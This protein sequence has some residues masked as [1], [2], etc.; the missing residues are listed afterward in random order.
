MTRSIATMRAISAARSRS[1]RP[2]FRA[3]ELPAAVQALERAVE[4]NRQFARAQR[5]LG[6]LYHALGRPDDALRALRR[7][8]QRDREVPQEALETSAIL[9]SLGEQGAAEDEVL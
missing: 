4:L 2:R 6:L 7:G 5:L 8:L 3:G 1:W 9:L